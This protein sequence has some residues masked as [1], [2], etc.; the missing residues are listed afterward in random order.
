M[1]KVYLS[2]SEYPG[3]DSA[4]AIGAFDGF[5]LGHQRIVKEL[6][7][8]SRKGSLDTV[9]YTFRRNPKL[10]TQKLGGLLSS[11]SE[12][13]ELASQLGV[14]SIVL[15]D[16]STRFQNLTPDYFVQG[17]LIGRL[18]ARVVVVGED[19]RFGRA[20]TGDVELM[21]RL[22]HDAGRRLVTVKPVLVD[23]KV[24]SSSVIRKA[25]LAGD[26]EGAAKYLGRSYSL[27]GVVVAGN[28]VGGKLGFPTANVDVSDP[29]KL[30]PGNGVYVV[31]ALIEGT[32]VG[33]VCNIG[34]RPTIVS[35][36]RRT[37]EVHLLDF[38]RQVYG[39]L[40]TVQFVA[41]LRDEQLFPSPGD[42]SRQISHDVAQAR[43]VLGQCD[44]VRK[45]IS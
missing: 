6:L 43:M 25:I 27:Q 38:H 5:H 33:G 40:V 19:F 9:V 35:G 31:R 42:L 28:H 21:A 3:V 37:V 29:M 14:D 8:M 11:N 39:R 13:V 24:C 36:S 12:R 23:G 17:V 2:S 41:R 45:K 22:L 30:L 34:V 18:N 15:E 10:T 20:R 32:V 1:S 7:A 16:F 44:A 26:V 4:V